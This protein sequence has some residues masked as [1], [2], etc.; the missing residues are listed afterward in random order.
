MAVGGAAVAASRAGNVPAPLTSFVGRRR[1]VAELR[2]RLRSARLLTVTGA[3]G[4]GKTRLALEVA[5]SSHRAFPDGVWLV[6]LAAVPESRGVVGATAATFGVADLDARPLAEKL[7]AHLADRTALLVLDNC[8]HV[9]D[10]CAELARTLLSAAP[11]L[12]VLATSRVSLGLTGEQLYTLA[13]LESADAADL[14]A[15][16]AAAL[17]PR[18][19]VDETNRATV[20]RLCA[21]L[22][23][24]P[25]AIEL[26][27][28]GLR[29]L[30]VDQ[31]IA[32][33]EDRFALLT[34]GRTAARPQQRTLRALVDWSHELCDPAERMLWRRLSVF[35]GSFTLE[36]AEQVCSGDGLATGRILDLLARL[37]AQSVVTPVDEAGER[38]YTLLET[39]R[40]YG[41]ERLSESG[42][43]QRVL[44]RHRAVHLRLAEEIA[45][46]WY[47]PGQEEALAR[48]RTEHADFA[49]ALRGGLA[50]E[51]EDTRAAL[52]TAA[53][54][55]TL[56][57]FGGQLGEG[58][59]WLERLLAAAP[60]PTAA[61]ATA[62]WVAAW[63]AMLQG[64]HATAEK[65]LSEADELGAARDDPLVRAYVE[66]LRGSLAV[67]QGKPEAGA[68][69]FETAIA[70]LRSLA[71]L[72]ETLFWLFQLAVV[73]ALT[74][75]PS[76]QEVGRQALALAEELGER[77]CRSYALLALAVD[78]WAR[79][80]TDAGRDFACRGLRLQRGFNEPIATAMLM[81]VLAWLTTAGGDHERAARLLGTADTLWR[82]SGTEPSSFAPELLGV[83]AKSA[84]EVLRTLGQAAYERAHAEGRRHD[85]LSSAIDFAL[86]DE[87]GPS[88]RAAPPGGPLT[89]REEQVA[90]LVAQGLSNRQ[91]A[92]TLARSP[93]TVDGHVEN[94]LAKLGFAS[95]AQIASWWTARS[96]PGPPTTPLRGGQD[97]R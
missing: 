13:P 46:R 93:R 21:G 57:C 20:A 18:F 80:Q 63:A 40:A 5:A 28:V 30:S 91:I 32:R 66:G 2:R 53:A 9:P 31:L 96:T 49:T 89:R 86:A 34:A 8:E 29:T 41:R 36:A 43:E 75:D 76:A 61:R 67:F 10:A 27:A 15:D 1:D 69:R 44:R 90:A 79:E 82:R 65:S 70:S 3:G 62:L 94:I 92:S 45:D 73:R 4:V 56:W 74:R 83:H 37:V 35:A 87:P 24:L 54:L 55:R 78:A 48:L 95:R 50:G 25:L 17:D 42:E 85:T 64:D 11:R 72:P 71:K 52:A 60:E 16:R 97:A 77:L 47:G 68:A 19:G 33:L 38:R 12:R 22:D 6:D 14:L 39:I 7:A 23:G 81:D 88:R 58:R 51:P 84:E 26:A 59:Y